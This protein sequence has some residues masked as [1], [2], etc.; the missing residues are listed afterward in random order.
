MRIGHGYDVHRY[1]QHSSPTPIRLG[2]VDVAAPHRL[3]AHSD[4]DVVLH[5]LCDALLGAIAQ[6]DIGEHFPDSDPTWENA[7]SADLLSQVY[8]WV[9][10]EG[11]ILQ[12]AD[13]SVIA[14]TPRLSPHKQ[15]MRCAIAE[16]LLTDPSAINVKA[17]T[18]EHMGPIGRG[19]GIA[20]HA[21]C[22]LAP[23]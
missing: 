6:G 9:Q 21:V 15:A 14:Q 20:A 22:L 3:L 8:Q 17:T 4:G 23:V 12:N 1:D 19:E 11:L 7:D 16:L 5:A 18:A 13:I 2:G 10:Q